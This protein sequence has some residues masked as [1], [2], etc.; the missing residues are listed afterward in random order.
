VAIACHG[1]EVRFAAAVAIALVACK[2]GVSDTNQMCG[3][4]S[5]MFSTCALGSN[6]TVEQRSEMEVAQNRWIR[7]CRAVYESSDAELRP[8]EKE[9]YNGLIADGSAG[10]AKEFECAAKATTCEQLDACE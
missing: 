8:A 10:A 7:L 2:P 6:A 5:V 1:D 4:A 9:L 3:K